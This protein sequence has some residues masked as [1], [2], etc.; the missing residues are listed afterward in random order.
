MKLKGAT[1]NFSK[2]IL[3][4]TFFILITLTAPSVFGQWFQ[5]GDDI[6][7]YVTGDR[8]GWSISISSD[9]NRI[10][11]GV[12]ENGT[13]AGS[14]GH[15]KILEWDGDDWIQMGL[16]ITAEADGDQFGRS[17]SLSGDGTI[18]AI[19]APYNGTTNAGH[20]RVYSW[21][22]TDWN[23]M[24][25]DIDGQAA[26]DFCG[27]SVAISEDGS[28][29]AVG[30]VN[31]D[32]A[33]SNSG[34]VRVYNW[35]GTSWNQLGTNIN[36]EFADDLA[37][38]SV[39][40]D[41]DGSTVAIGSIGNDGSGSESGHVRVFSWTGSTWS[42]VGTPIVGE[43]ALDRSGCSISLSDNG[44]TIAIGAYNNDGTGSNSGHV[45]VFNWSG[46]TWIQIGADMNGENAEDQFGYSVALNGDGSTLIAGGRYNDETATNAGHARVFELSGGSWSQVGTDI[47]GDNS[48]DESGWSVD[49]SEDGMTVAVGAHMND[50]EGIDAGHVKVY[51]PCTLADTPIISASSTDLCPFETVTLTI[52][53]ELYDAENWSIYTGSC[54]GT[55]VGTTETSTIDLNPTTTTTYYIRAE[56]GCV[57]AGDCETIEITVQT[58]NA[59]VTTDEA[60]ATATEVGAGIT[61]QWINCDDFSILPGETD[62]SYTATGSGSY[63]VIVTDNGCVD[64]SFCVDLSDCENSTISSLTASPSIKCKNDEST[65]SISG[66]LNGGAYWAIY[67]GS[68]NETLEGI[69]TSTTFTVSPETSAAYFVR[70]E[71][72][73]IVDPSDCI[74]TTVIV[75]PVETEVSIIG[76]GV[77]SAD[78]EGAGITYQW[79][80]CSDESELVGE[81][82]KTFTPD[83]EEFYAVIINDNGCID[84]SE[85]IN[86]INATVGDSKNDLELTVYPNPSNG[87]FTLKLSQGFI[88]S[89]ELFNFEGRLIQSQQ[90]N[91]EYEIEFDATGNEAG[92]YL[93]RVIDGTNTKTVKLVIN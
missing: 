23:Q 58:V 45:R 5:K 50:N 91:H 72:G 43:A 65:L 44:E 6:N 29:V 87:I 85:C 59:T 3:N 86:V 40:L 17:V 51:A 77:L 34:H 61:Y 73:C 54:G 56:G 83:D 57:G 53:G 7:G 30:A 27:Y 79:I 25:S 41:T 71:G 33:G 89:V 28:T 18:V 48:G 20:A 93:L 78:T 68:C 74:S 75:S 80:R 81:T 31:N 42:I 47:D 49:I 82:F 15:V 67:S 90:I 26:N 32:A 36:G 16:N 69:T 19:G 52:S 1:K 55:L 63:A 11:I 22:G 37:G 9:G 88:G 13:G 14:A 60:T 39:S 12:P 4:Y 66:E 92:M 70:G 24:G 2:R 76:W 8:S 64:T 35:D 46:S 21:T 62:Q 38:Y 84:T 10:A